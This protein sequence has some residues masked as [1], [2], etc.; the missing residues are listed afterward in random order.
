MQTL[1]FDFWLS[2]NFWILNF[3]MQFKI[4]KGNVKRQNGMYRY[5]LSWLKKCGFTVLSWNKHLTH[6]DKVIHHEIFEVP[7]QRGRLKTCLTN[8]LVILNFVDTS[9]VTYPKVKTGIA[10]RVTILTSFPLIHTFLSFLQCFL[11]FRYFSI[12]VLCLWRCGKTRGGQAESGME[13]SSS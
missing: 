9:Q 3:H 4:G 1:L 8:R 5:F 6:T 11:F 7:E 2:T 10:F 12:S 13:K